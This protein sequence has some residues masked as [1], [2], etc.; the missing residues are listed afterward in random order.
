MT[1]EG[2][3]DAVIGSFGRQCVAKRKERAEFRGIGGAGVDLKVEVGQG[4]QARRNRGSLQLD[5]DKAHR[6]IPRIHHVVRD[7]GFAAIA[8]SCGEDHC[9]A[10]APWFFQ[11]HLT[12][13]QRCDHIIQAMPVPAGFGPRREIEP[14]DADAGI[15]DQRG[16]GALGS[17]ALPPD[18][19]GNDRFSTAQVAC[20]SA[21]RARTGASL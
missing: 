14:G 12:F 6:C 19:P 9:P 18:W 13:G 15:V 7:P 20:K 11:Q 2:D 10:S 4:L 1:C 17:Q 21:C 5:F 3:I 8:G 16:G